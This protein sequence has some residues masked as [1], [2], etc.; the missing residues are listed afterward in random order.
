MAL[1][2]VFTSSIVFLTLLFFYELTTRSSLA[3]GEGFAFILGS[4]WNPVG[5]F[6]DVLLMIHGSIVTSAMILLTGI[7]MSGCHLL[8]HLHD[9][10]V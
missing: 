9:H 4:E 2:F 8:P 10:G 5:D 1:L 7:P 3:L 6:Y